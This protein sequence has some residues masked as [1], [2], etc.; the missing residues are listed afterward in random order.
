MQERLVG[1]SAVAEIL[2]A[3]Y[4]SST[5]ERIDNAV[6][7]HDA[8]AVVVGIGNIDVAGFIYYNAL[9]RVELR[10]RS[11]A[12]GAGT[13][14]ARVAGREWGGGSAVFVY[15]VGAAEIGVAG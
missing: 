15:R 14:G 4:L 6:R 1:R 3:A 9:R 7:G 11:R 10:S 5:G 12:A 8:D 13:P 2:H